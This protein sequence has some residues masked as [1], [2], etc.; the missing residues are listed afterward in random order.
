MAIKVCSIEIFSFDQAVDIPLL[1][2][3]VFMIAVKN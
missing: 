3:A 2:F 1:I